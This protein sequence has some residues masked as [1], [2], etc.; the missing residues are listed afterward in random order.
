[1]LYLIPFFLVH[2]VLMMV[3]EFYFHYKRGLGRWERLGHPFDTSLVILCYAWAYYW[4]GSELSSMF[5]A[6][7][8]LLVAGSMLAIAK[9]EWVHQ[10]E[11]LPA[12][13]WVHSLLFMF[14][15][16]FCNL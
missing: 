6:V 15:P 8:A 12:E 1:M 13:Q 7:Y 4:Q 11:C 9:D 5:Y 16:V 2:A 3:D 10:A 14:H